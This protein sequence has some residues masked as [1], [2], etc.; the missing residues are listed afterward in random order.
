MDDCMKIKVFFIKK[1]LPHK[2]FPVKFLE[3][4]ISTEQLQW[5]LF[6]I[7]DSNRSVQRC[8]SDISYTHPISDNMQ[9]PQLQTN[10]KMHSLTKNLFQ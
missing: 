1:R 3:T 7:G 6:K 8:F 9:L 5:L 4:P 2:C 10:L